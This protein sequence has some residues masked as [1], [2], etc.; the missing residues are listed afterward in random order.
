[1]KRVGP[2]LKVRHHIV[3]MLAIDFIYNSFNVLST[4]CLFWFSYSLTAEIDNIGIDV[5]TTEGTTQLL[6]KRSLILS[7]QIVTL[8]SRV[9]LVVV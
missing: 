1:M 8:I 4:V 6:L 9:V 3:L 7:A 5:K 2:L